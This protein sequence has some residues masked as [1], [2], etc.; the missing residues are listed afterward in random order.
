MTVATTAGVKKAEL[1]G[2][3]CVGWEEGAVRY[4]IEGMC[5]SA[6]GIDR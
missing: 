6:R 3:G 4:M 2:L 5:V 1:V